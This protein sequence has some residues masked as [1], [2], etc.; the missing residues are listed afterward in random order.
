MSGEEQQP[1]APAS[2]QMSQEE[3]RQ[4]ARAAVGNGTAPYGDG[5]I[6]KIRDILFGSHLQH[7]SGQFTR[8]ESLIQQETA[9]LRDTLL[10]R[11]DFL[12]SYIKTEVESLN[13]RLTAEQT[14]RTSAIDQL[15]QDAKAL[16]N[17]FEEKTEQLAEQTAEG[18]HE[19]RELLLEQSK[20]LA[21]DIRNRYDDISAL[22]AQQLEDLRQ[23]KTDRAALASLFGEMAMRLNQELSRSELPSERDEDKSEST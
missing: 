18:Q 6:E 14:T 15:V 1:R 10:R 19:L 7:I 11:C 17:Q 3:L 5:H 2:G 9:D 8:L 22:L 12:E 13:Q 21:E 4:A 16:G 23:V 20:A